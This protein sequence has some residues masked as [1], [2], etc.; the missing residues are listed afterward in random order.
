M[1][2]CCIISRF[3]KY[4]NNNLPVY[5][6]MLPLDINSDIHEHNTRNS[7][8]LHIRRANHVFAKKCLR[9][10]IPNIINSLDPTIRNKVY[11]HSLQGFAKY[12]KM[13]LILSYNEHCTISNC[14]VCA[15][16]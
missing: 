2:S 12:V 6:Q 13:K 7:H 8:N 9:I 10:D 14:Y 1:A 15:H 5:F 16:Q 11:T 4:A 3:V